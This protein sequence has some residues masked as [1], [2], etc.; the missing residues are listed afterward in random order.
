[1]SLA[2]PA[3]IITQDPSG[4]NS[5]NAAERSLTNTL[6]TSGAQTQAAGNALTDAGTAEVQP[7]LD[8]WTGILSGN[9]ADVAAAAAPQITA[10]NQQFQSQSKVLDQYTPM[11]GGRSQ[12]V[13]ANKTAQAQTN[14]NIISNTRAGAAPALAQTATT[15]QSAGLQQQSLGIQ[16]LG[17]AI[18]AILSK[19]GIDQSGDFANSFNSIMNGIG[20]II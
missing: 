14:A 1:M 20:A 18:Q 15:E 19:M 10:S 2:N 17:Q 3:S 16:Q 7:A 13:A 8:Y 4:E 9:Q 12:A 6:S 11:G 5:A